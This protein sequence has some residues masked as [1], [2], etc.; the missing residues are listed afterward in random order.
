M[1]LLSWWINMIGIM[2]S[3]A[4]SIYAYIGAARD[5]IGFDDTSGYPLS[6]QQKMNMINGFTNRK[7]FSRY[8]FLL[9]IIGFILF[10]IAQVFVYPS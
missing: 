8:G 2:I 5:T 10:G 6:D 4:G 1:A 9:L 3:L 7:K